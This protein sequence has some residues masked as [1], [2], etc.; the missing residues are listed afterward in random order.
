MYLRTPKRYRR[1]RRQLHLFSGRA[2]V[3]LLMIPLIGAIGWYLWDHQEQF[4]SSVVPHIEGF[5]DSMQTQ[6]APAPSPTATADLVSAQA[7]CASAFQQGQTEIAIEECKVLAEGRPN[8]VDLYY[9]LT[10]ML[11][12][13]SSFGRDTARLDEALAYAEKTINANPEKP[14]GWAIRAMALDWRGDPEKALASALQAKALDEQFAPTYAFMGEIYHDLDQNEMALT[15][16][17]RA[18]ELDTAGIAVAYTFRTRGLIYS[19]QGNYED[20]I[21]PYQA[22]MQN[23]PNEGFI[24]IELAN[25]YKAMN[26]LD[27]AIQ[28]L[29][30][31]LEQNPTDTMALW[32]LAG[33]YWRNGDAPKAAEY[34][35]RCLE[36]DPDNVACLSYLGGLQFTDGD[37]ATAIVNLQRAV[38]LGSEDPSDFYQLGRSQAALG[39]C[40]LGVPYL[41][42]GY[43]IAVAQEDEQAQQNLLSSLQSCGALVPGPPSTAEPTTSP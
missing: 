3:T 20:A 16:L 9:R 29:A 18:L 15:Y 7:G 41:Q 28:V 14:Q 12:T 36:V 40:D 34:Y 26:E 22:A 32:T 24:A 1:Q 13:T 10:Y 5:R 4:R 25:N 27:R 8:D 6:V 11:V 37:Y 2:V 33:I 42:Q 30:S 19:S 38:E 23:A 17:D 43:Q 39:R 21:Q 35:Q 31:V